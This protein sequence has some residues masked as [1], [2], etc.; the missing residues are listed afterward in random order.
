M[1]NVPGYTLA[2][3]DVRLPANRA[4]FHDHTY[5]S[6]GVLADSYR[7]GL[8]R[9]LSLAFEMD[10]REFDRSEY[11]NGLGEAAGIGHA[12]ELYTTWTNPANG[13]LQAR[14]SRYP[15]FPGRAAGAVGSADPRPRMWVP[16]W[17]QNPDNPERNLGTNGSRYKAWSWCSS[18]RTRRATP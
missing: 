2:D 3:P 11:G 1:P 13:A 5:W 17:E 4:S 18:G 9:D 6:A 12:T 7:G 16:I 14:R 10:D 8:R 15:G